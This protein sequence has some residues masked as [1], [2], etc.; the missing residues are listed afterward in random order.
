[1]KRPIPSILVLSLLMFLVSWVLAETLIV[2]VQTTSL[3]RTP[4]FYGPVIQVL[5]AGEKI[6]KVSSQPDGWI[7]VRTSGGVVGW[8]HSSAVEV[9]KFG[10]LAMNKGLKTQASTSEVALAG[11]GFNKQIEDNYRTQHKEANFAG[12]DR[13]LQIKVPPAQIEEFMKQGKLGEWKGAK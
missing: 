12:V 9:Q 10:L 7:Q 4:K 6:D 1:V 13:M 2:K 11:K 8:V 3:R 5:P